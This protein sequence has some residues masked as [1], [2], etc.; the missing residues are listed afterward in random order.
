[1]KSK[2]NSMLTLRLPPLNG[3]NVSL[4]QQSP[5]VAYN[6]KKHSVIHIDDM[7]TLQ[8]CG[9][10][11]SDSAMPPIFRRA[12][13]SLEAIL[14]NDCRSMESKEEKNKQCLKL[15]M[16]SPSHLL[17]KFKRSTLVK[18]MQ[19]SSL[20]PYSHMKKCKAKLL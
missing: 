2:N 12:G 9:S 1:M 5:S 10:P 19:Q 20:V 13:M 16:Y 11:T 7:S 18:F 17:K 4:Q 15:C 3:I 14:I 8:K 6:K